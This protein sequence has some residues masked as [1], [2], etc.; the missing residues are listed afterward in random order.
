MKRY[1][2]VYVTLARPGATRARIIYRCMSV[3]AA[4]RFIA[5]REQRDPKG[6]HRG[7][8]GIDATERAEAIY[9]RGPRRRRLSATT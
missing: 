5:A 7:D 3:R 9:Q 2:E 8:Y 4:E 6:V 1:Y